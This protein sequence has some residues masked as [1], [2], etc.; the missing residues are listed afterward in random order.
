MLR[1]GISEGGRLHAERDFRTVSEEFATTRPA[2]RWRQLVALARVT[3]CSYGYNQKD[4]AGHRAL[5]Y[6]E[7]CRLLEVQAQKRRELRTVPAGQP[8]ALSVSD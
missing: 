4:E 1:Y 8:S 2:F 3:A 5:G 6:E 7:A